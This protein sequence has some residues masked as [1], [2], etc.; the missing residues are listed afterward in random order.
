[1]EQIERGDE[2]IVKTLGKGY[3]LGEC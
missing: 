3:H 2:K 1:M